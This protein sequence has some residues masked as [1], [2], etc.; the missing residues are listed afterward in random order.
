MGSVTYSFHQEV[1]L[2]KTAN[3]TTFEHAYLNALLQILT[4]SP[5]QLTCS[6]EYSMQMFT[7]NCDIQYINGSVPSQRILVDLL[8]SALS[9]ALS[10]LPSSKDEVVDISIPMNITVIGPQ[11]K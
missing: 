11:G 5:D 10:Q 8:S 3:A 2:N 6:T 9:L 1:T 7:A 4:L